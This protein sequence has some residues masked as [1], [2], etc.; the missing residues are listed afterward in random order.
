MTDGHELMRRIADGDFGAFE[1]L[2]DGQHRLV[3]GIAIRMLE[4][5]TLAEDLTQEIFTKIW[6]D[7]LAFRGG[8]LVGWIARMTRNRAIDLMRSRAIRLESEL[9][10]T[11]RFEHLTDEEAFARLESAAIRRAVDALPEAQRTLI[12]MGFF[13][14]LTH[15]QIARRTGVPLGTVKTRIRSGLHKMRSTLSETASE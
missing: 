6:S 2:Y 10:E 1:E 12:L 5:P 4:R 13:G 8:N 15:E 14:G 9:P 3:Y 7:P 11:L